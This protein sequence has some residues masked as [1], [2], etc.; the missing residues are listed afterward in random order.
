M[1]QVDYTS[2]S[3][4]SPPYLNKTVGVNVYNGWLAIIMFGIKTIMTGM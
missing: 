2:A 4:T 3:L 1:I